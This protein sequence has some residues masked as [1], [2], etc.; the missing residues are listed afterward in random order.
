[1]EQRRSRSGAIEAERTR[2]MSL[3][4]TLGFALLVCVVLVLM[5]PK[6][7]LIEQVRNV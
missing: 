3:G 5:F 6:Q 4:A 1:M 2:V 7:A